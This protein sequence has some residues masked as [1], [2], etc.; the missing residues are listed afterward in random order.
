M[1][2]NTLRDVKLLNRVQIYCYLKGINPS[3]YI[4][5]SIRKQLNK[6]IASYNRYDKDRC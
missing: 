3:D 4:M 6:D 5:K 2:N 1:F